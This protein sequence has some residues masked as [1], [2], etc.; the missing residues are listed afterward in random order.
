MGK[1]VNI[2]GNTHFLKIGQSIDYNLALV[3]FEEDN[4]TFCY[5]PTLDITGYGHN[6]KEANKSFEITL[7]EYFD[8]TLKEKTLKA[9]LTR[10][11]WHYQFLN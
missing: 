5:C 8:Y 11:G 1:H 3:L 10:L 2:A 4:I 6:E 7:H 9:D